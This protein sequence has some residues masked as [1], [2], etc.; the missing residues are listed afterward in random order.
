MQAREDYHHFGGTGRQTDH[1]LLHHGVVENG[2]SFILGLSDAHRF[3][4]ATTLVFLSLSLLVY[5]QLWRHTGGSDG[6]DVALCVDAS[7]D[8]VAIAGYTTGDL[9]SENNGE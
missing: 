4:G 7:E 1:L 8:H 2:W 3:G 5:A 9:Y 6:E